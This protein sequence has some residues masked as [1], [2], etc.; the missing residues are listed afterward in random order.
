MVKESVDRTMSKDIK[1]GDSV[2]IPCALLKLWLRELPEP[3]IPPQL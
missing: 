1:K 3:L 2:H